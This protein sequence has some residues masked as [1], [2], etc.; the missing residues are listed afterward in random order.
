MGGI[1]VTPLLV[2][3]PVCNAAVG[4]PCNAPT[5]TGRRDVRWFHSSRE[6]TASGWTKADDKS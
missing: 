4:R 1:T 6:N 3:C 2:P 5:E